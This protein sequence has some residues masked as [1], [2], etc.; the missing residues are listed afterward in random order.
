[1]HSKKAKKGK[2]HDASKKAEAEKIPEESGD[3]ETDAG[4]EEAYE[5]KVR[6]RKQTVMDPSGIKEQAN[7][8]SDSEGDA[9]RLTHETVAAKKDRSNKQRIKHAHHVPPDE[10]NEQRDARTIFLGNVPTDVA[11]HKVCPSSFLP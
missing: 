10:T 2:G 7:D 11:K 4:L 1:L 3:E 5:R 9:S 6:P 8:T